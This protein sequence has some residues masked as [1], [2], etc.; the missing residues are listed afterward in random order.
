[1]KKE[2]FLDTRFTQSRKWIF[3]FFFAFSLEAL[4]PH[5]LED[6][7]GARC[8]ER[9]GE[10]VRTAAGRLQ[11]LS[12]KT[13]TKQSKQQPTAGDAKGRHPAAGMKDAPESKTIRAERAG[14]AALA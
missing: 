4:R 11:P 8:R 10:Q 6:A 5:L 1:M 13:T 3:F 9:R 2:V 12:K 14:V 7:A